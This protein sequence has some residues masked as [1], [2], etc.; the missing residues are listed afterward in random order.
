M[1]RTL[2]LSL[3]LLA[4]AS[5]ASRKPR[6]IVDEV[7]QENI[8]IQ[9]VLD[10]ARSSYLKGCVDGKNIFA[11]ETQQSSFETCRDHAM[12]H[13]EEIRSILEQIPETKRHPAK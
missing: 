11:A 9:T 12:K 1:L 13:Q 7:S 2:I 3:V 4:A 6:S 5:C 8:S 10:L